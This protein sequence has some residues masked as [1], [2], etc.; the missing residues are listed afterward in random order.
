MGRLVVATPVAG[1]REASDDRIRLASPE[2]FPVVLVEALAAA[3]PFPQHSDRPVAS[4]DD[5]VTQMAEV[6]ERV[7]HAATPQ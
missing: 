7:R 5:R 1:F 2:D 4:W 6:I 3:W